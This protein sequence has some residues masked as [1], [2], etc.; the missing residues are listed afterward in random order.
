MHF[1][2]GRLKHIRGVLEMLFSPQNKACISHEPLVTK[3]GCRLSDGTHF[4]FKEKSIMVW[5]K[6]AARCVAISNNM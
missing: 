2:V 1:K 5:K 3:S 6:T 4:F